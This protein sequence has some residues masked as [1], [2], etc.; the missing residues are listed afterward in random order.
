MVPFPT[1]VDPPLVDPLLD[2]PAASAI[3]LAVALA[4]GSPAPV[5][6]PGRFTIAAGRER[7]EVEY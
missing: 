7:A 3:A 2:A 1:L 6:T 5:S 4:A